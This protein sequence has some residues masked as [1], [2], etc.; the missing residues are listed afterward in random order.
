MAATTPAGSAPYYYVPAPSRH[1]VLLA[2]G[3]FLVILG[4]G[5]VA[6]DILVPAA[7]AHSA[8]P[9]TSGV[10][11]ARCCPPSSAIICPVIELF[12]HR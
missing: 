1:P 8:I 12:C 11:Q 4:A 9:S 3:L 6:G 7:A 10:R 2:A 5:H